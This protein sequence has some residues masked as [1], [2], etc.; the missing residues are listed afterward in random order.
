MGLGKG[1]PGVEELVEA[2]LVRR[3]AGAAVRRDAVHADASIRSEEYTALVMGKEVVSGRQDFACE[4]AEVPAF[5]SSHISQVSKV[6][7]LREVRALRGFTRLVEPCLDTPAERIAPLSRHVDDW[8]PALEVIGEG[9]FI[10]VDHD[11]LDRWAASRFAQ[12]R[13]E[14]LQINTDR[15]ADAYHRPRTD[16]VDI[17][18]VALHSLAH[19]LI[20][21]FSLDAGYPA[22]SLRERLYSSDT[23]SGL[24]VY[25]ATSDSAGSLGGLASLSEE[26]EMAHAFAAGLSRLSWCSNDPV[27][28]ESTGS[29]A[30]GLNLAA[31][32]ACLLLPETSCESQNIHLDRATLFGTAEHPTEGLLS[33]LL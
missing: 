28:I 31:C 3:S 4:R 27:C 20:D 12:G 29:G 22:A 16:A 33:D 10:Q 6:S 2:I 26:A 7:R 11:V 19:L 30:D 32:H 8:L 21:Q 9:V 15:R 5:L 14:L 17:R 24:L 1:T 23:M 25:T 13:Q 18:T